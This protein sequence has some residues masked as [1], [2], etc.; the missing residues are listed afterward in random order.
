MFEI[1]NRNLAFCCGL[2]LNMCVTNFYSGSHVHT[3]STHPPLWFIDTALKLKAQLSKSNSIFQ[4]FG[5]TQLWFEL[6]IS[7]SGGKRS[8]ITLPVGTLVYS[9]DSNCF[10]NVFTSF[11]K[12]N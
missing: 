5:M 10:H 9:L 1:F 8:T 12:F 2:G 11:F 3:T 7:R 4:V 6:T